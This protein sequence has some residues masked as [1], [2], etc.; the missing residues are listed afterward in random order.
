[1]KLI[2]ALTVILSLASASTINSRVSS[3]APKTRTLEVVPE[4]HEAVE[5]VYPAHHQTSHSYSG[6]GNSYPSYGHH[7]GYSKEYLTTPH[8]SSGAQYSSYGTNYSP[9]YTN[10]I[11]YVVPS[12]GVRSDHHVNTYG[13]QYGSQYGSQHGSRHWDDYPWIEPSYTQIMRSRMLHV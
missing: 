7:S 2:L 12:H 10:E 5:L 4:I 6:Y 1:M 8:Y 11:E 9:H 13:T 3:R